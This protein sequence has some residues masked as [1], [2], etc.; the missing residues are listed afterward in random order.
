MSAQ[1]CVS[2]IVAVG[3]RGDWGMITSFIIHDLGWQAGNKFGWF[4]PDSDYPLTGLLSEMRPVAFLAPSALPSTDLRKLPT[5][6]L[7]ARGGLHMC[8]QA[9]LMLESFAHSANRLYPSVLS[10][11]RIRLSQRGEEN[12]ET[13]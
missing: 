10:V 12:R 8:E 2:T 4:T 5:P 1:S 9:F 7:R 13:G 3:R 6:R 11:P